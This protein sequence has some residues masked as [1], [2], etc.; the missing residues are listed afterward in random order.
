MPALHLE[1]WVSLRK[2][3]ARVHGLLRKLYGIARRITQDGGGWGP[4][5]FLVDPDPAKPKTAR[6]RAIL[7]LR[8]DEDLWVE[9]V[10]YPNRVRMR[11]IIRRI[12]QHPQVRANADALD[13]LVSRRKSGYQATIAY[14]T[15]KTM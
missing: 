8:S 13:G 1:L 10:F 15:I 6:L 11:N 3:R 12:W 7:G 4:W 9:L 5:V 14:A 2:D